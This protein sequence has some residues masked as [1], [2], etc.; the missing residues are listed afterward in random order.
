MSTTVLM[1]VPLWSP[2]ERA[3]IR[4]SR[5]RARQWGRSKAGPHGEKYFFYVTYLPCG[6][7]S[8]TKSCWRQLGLLSA[9]PPR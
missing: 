1:R 3:G 7:P 4:Q 6:P 8:N 2:R 5:C 9:F